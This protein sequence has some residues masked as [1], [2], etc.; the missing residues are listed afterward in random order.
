MSNRFKFSNEY[1]SSTVEGSKMMT[2][3][4]CIRA[5]GV[6]KDRNAESTPLNRCMVAQ[7]KYELHSTQHSPCSKISA[8]YPRRTKISNITGSHAKLAISSPRRHS[9]APLHL[10]EAIAVHLIFMQDP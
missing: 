5:V 3:T 10:R 2:P 6:S 7:T 1:P 4:M 9:V 8:F